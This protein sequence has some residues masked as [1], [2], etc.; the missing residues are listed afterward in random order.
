MRADRQTLR[1]FTRLYLFLLASLVRRVA[2]GGFKSAS[3]CTSTRFISRSTSCLGM[4]GFSSESPG[5]ESLRPT[6]PVLRP[7]KGKPRLP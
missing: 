6:S 4:S 2:P 5:R 1:L 3:A 7:P